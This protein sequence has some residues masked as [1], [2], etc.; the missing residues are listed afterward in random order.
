MFTL[1]NRKKYTNLIVTTTSEILLEHINNKF[2]AGSMVI[3]LHFIYVIY[4]MYKLVSADIVSSYY[5]Y[6]IMWI[7]MIYSNYYF[8]G[9]ILTRIE[10]YIL[11]TKSWA[12]HVSI[13]F[14]PLHIFYQPNK[15]I[16]NDY[17]KYFWCAPISTVIILKYL[18]EDDYFNKSIGLCLMTILI[19]LLFI[20]SQSDALFDKVHNYLN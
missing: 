2:V 20:Y 7:V 6:T 17:I 11:Q 10:Q 13:L 15:Q 1:E 19:P 3:L 18:C 12:G 8:H 4:T 16:I 9:C 5:L 14:F